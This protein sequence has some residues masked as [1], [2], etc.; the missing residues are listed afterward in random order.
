MTDQE[1]IEALSNLFRMFSD[2]RYHLAKFLVD[3]GAVSES[4]LSKLDCAELEY[5]SDFSDI[6]EIEE[7]FAS[8]L[9]Q[10]EPP[11]EIDLKAKL[12]DLIEAEKYEDAARLRDYMRKIKGGR[13]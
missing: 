6:D 8:L 3:H 4:F 9:G 13:R 1:K 2:K 7:H 11:Q 10:T 5:R 12:M